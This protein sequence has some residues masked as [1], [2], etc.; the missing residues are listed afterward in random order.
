MTSKNKTSDAVTIVTSG[1]SID[2]NQY[3]DT[4]TYSPSLTVTSSFELD[5]GINPR[6]GRAE[7]KVKVSTLTSRK[8]DKIEK[9][10]Q[11]LK[12]LGELV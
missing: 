7:N 5:K 4:P 10:N 1:D 3:S 12:R 9:I 2:F 8:Q 11:R 6:Y